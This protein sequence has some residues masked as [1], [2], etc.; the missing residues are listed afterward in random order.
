MAGAVHRACRRTGRTRGRR[1]AADFVAGTA[2]AACR[3]DFAAGAAL[4]EPAAQI[5]WQS[6][7]E[8]WMDAW[9]PLG[10]G[11]RCW[12]VDFA[13]GAVRRACKRSGW[14]SELYGVQL[15]LALPLFKKK[16]RAACLLEK[17]VLNGHAMLHPR[18]LSLSFPHSFFQSRTAFFIVSYLSVLC[19][20]Q[21]LLLITTTHHT[22]LISF[23]FIVQF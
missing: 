19:S 15:T 6:L 23:T 16:W 5:S 1:W 9:T 10:R 7:E 2:L 13:A 22:P 14:Y 4:G 17:L 20:D 21:S 3:A 18:V 8:D 11:R 12:S